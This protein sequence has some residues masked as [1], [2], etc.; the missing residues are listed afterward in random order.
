MKHIV[1]LIAVGMISAAVS[2]QTTAELLDQSPAKKILNKKCIQLETTELLPIEFQTACRVLAQP[3]LLEAVQAEFIRSISKTGN[4]D[5]PVIQTGPTTYYYINETG[6]Q[7]DIVERYRKQTD[8]H[9]FNY[10]VQATGKRF[11]GDFDVIIHL[12]VVDAGSAGIVYSVITYAYPHN[13]ITRFYLRNIGSAKKYF[14]SKMRMIS[15]VAREIAIELCKKEAFKLGV[16]E[17]P[18]LHTFSPQ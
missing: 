10:V 1:L 4:V 7:V 9:S 17:N 12:Q 6:K 18:P 2:A 15:S 14:K 11:F 5:F 13:F 3:H 16:S 8:A